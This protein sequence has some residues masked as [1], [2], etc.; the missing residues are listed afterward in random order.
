M[1]RADCGRFSLLAR[2][3][4]ESKTFPNLD[5]IGFE[6]TDLRLRADCAGLWQD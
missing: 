3:R 4:F 6:R 2:R 5:G 1:K